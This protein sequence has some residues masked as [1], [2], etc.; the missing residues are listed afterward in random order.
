MARV[1]KNAPGGDNP[2][3]FAILIYESPSDI[4]RREGKE[5]KAYMDAWKAYTAALQAAGVLVSGAG[6]QPTHAATTIRSK[7]GK[8]LVQDGPYAETKDQFGGFYIIEAASLDAAL[9]WASKCPSLPSGAVEVR[10]VLQ[11]GQ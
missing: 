3:K 10:P 2:M 1:P 6:L 9:E 7:D 8:R 11:T 5:A 4:T